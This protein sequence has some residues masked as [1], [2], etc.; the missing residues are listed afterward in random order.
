M[1]PVSESILLQPTLKAIYRRT[2]F[3]ENTIR[4]KEDRIKK[5]KKNE[6]DEQR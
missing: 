6:T 1:L 5:S 3:A 2:D 4:D